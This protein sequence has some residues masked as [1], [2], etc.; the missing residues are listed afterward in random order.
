MP[1][2][3]VTPQQKCRWAHHGTDVLL[4][5]R[6]SMETGQPGLPQRTVHYSLAAVSSM[7][8]GERPE[9]K[10]LLLEQLKPFN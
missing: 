2:P 5:D 10:T 6:V 1:H 8:G 3:L 9:G 4:T 7:F